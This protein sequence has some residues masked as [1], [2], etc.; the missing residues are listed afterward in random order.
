M[1]SIR[2]NIHDKIYNHIMFL[3]KSMDKED[4]KIVED[5]D[6]QEIQNTKQSIKKLFANKDFEVFKSIKD[7]MKW[8]EEQRLEW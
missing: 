2:L 5:R 4:L 6:L 7:P 3:L 8:Q 1:R